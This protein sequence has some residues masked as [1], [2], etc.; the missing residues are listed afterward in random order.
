MDRRHTRVGRE[1]ILE[2]AE[3]LFTKHGFQAVS[4]RDIAKN[5]QVTSAALY[6][7]FPSKEVLFEAV[8]ERHAENLSA[9]MRAA[10]NMDGSFMERAIAILWEYSQVAA[11]RRSPV[12]MLRREKLNIGNVQDR[13]Q[14]AR[15]MHAMLCPLEELITHA[16]EAGE[17][18]LLPQ[19]FS[20]AALLVGLLHGHAVY[21]QACQGDQLDRQDVEMV[22]HIFW[23]GVTS[24]V[25]DR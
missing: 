1:R 16:V 9:R 4:I 20:P 23:Q 22:V 2:V 11:D 14:H 12:F 18:Q 17:V 8:M 25:G 15:L 6:Y 19:G 5:C 7:H 10:A 3:E 13:S 24:S 21:R